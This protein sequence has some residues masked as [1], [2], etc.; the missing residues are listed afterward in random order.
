MISLICGGMYFDFKE[1]GEIG[2]VETSR[3][4]KLDIGFY[5]SWV[6]LFAFQKVG[7]GT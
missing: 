1:S 3:I 7:V 4:V 5:L 6:N 2:D